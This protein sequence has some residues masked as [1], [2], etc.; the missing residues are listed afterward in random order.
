M[1]LSIAETGV[2]CRAK[3]QVI[4]REREREREREQQIRL[5]VIFHAL[6]S[7]SYARNIRNKAPR[8]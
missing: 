2:R 3:E 7:V 6:H 4:E 8:I 5:K 1:Y